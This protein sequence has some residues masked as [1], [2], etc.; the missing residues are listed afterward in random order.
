MNISGNHLVKE[1]L[2][3]QSTSVFLISDLNQIF[4]SNMCVCYL[5]VVGRGVNFLPKSSMSAAVPCQSQGITTFLY[6][7]LDSCL[8]LTFCNTFW[9]LWH[10]QGQGNNPQYECIKI[11][12]IF[13]WWIILKKHPHLMQPN[14]RIYICIGDALH[15]RNPRKSE[16]SRSSGFGTLSTPDTS[17]IIEWLHHG[18][19]I[20]N[21]ACNFSRFL[22]LG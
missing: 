21:L 19:P 12:I 16:A 14:Q 4:I 2:F 17:K 20:G 11:K 13:R 5:W 18:L 10:K 9:Y 8:S 22:N 3:V 7:E 6:I 1:N 15:S